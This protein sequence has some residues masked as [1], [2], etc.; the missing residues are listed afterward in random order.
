VLFG[1]SGAGESTIDAAQFFL[2][3]G[4]KLYGFIIFH[5]VKRR[6][7]GEG[8]ARLAQLVAE[9]AL[10]PRI[11]VERPWTEIAEVAQGL[12]DRRFAGKAVLQVSE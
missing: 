1:R 11:A 12:L 5:E 8:L 4:A 7:A 2:N 3:G 9:G 10:R 6:P